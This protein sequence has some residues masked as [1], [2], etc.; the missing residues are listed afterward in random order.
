MQQLGV[1][2]LTY[3]SLFI[4]NCI[5]S[6]NV[7]VKNTFIVDESGRVR[8]YHGLI[9]LINYFRMMWSGVEPEPNKYNV[10]YLNIMKNIIELLESNHI[11]VLL[12]MH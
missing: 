8:I 10:T 4:A 11:F 12:D 6:A 3:F 7:H 1:C 9:L 5:G 2:L